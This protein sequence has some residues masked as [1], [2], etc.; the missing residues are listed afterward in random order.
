[1]KHTIGIRREDKNK[2][3]RRVPVVPADMADSIAVEKLQFVVQSSSL[4][5][6]TDDAFRKAGARVDDSLD[7]CGVVLAVKEIPSRLFRKG[8]TYVFFTHTVKGQRHNMG[9]LRRLMALKCNVID[10][11][12]IVNAAGQRLIFF[13]RHAGLAGMIDTLWG[14]GQ[15]LAFERVKPNPLAEVKLAHQYPNLAAA[16]DHLR[17]I[18]A[19]IARE[20]LPDGLAPFVVGFTGYGNVSAGAQEVLDTFP[21][22]TI[23]PEALAGLHARHACATDKIYKVVFREEHMA[24]PVDGGPFDLQTYYRHPERYRAAFD[25][26]L[27]H[28]TV[29]MNCI[30]W[31]RPYPR[32]ITKAALK[33]MFALSGG[34]RLKAIGDI[35]CDI[36]GAIE[37]TVKAT[38]P[39]NPVYVYE[40]EHDRAVDGVQ[41]NGPLIMAVDNLP[42]EFSQ[43]ASVYFSRALKPFLPALAAADYTVPFQQ[44]AL[45]P[46]IKGALIVHQGKFTP[47]YAFM[48][49][50]VHDP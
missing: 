15:R 3:E 24:Q 28:L 22:E 33:Q 35:S 16:M 38:E 46:E 34:A 32:L 30:Y 6:F 19:Q 21:V 47:P 12:R 9:M 29:L 23:A 18:G 40:P 8:V 14:V 26:Y 48:Q 42:C 37:A 7:S 17:R 50:F 2:W 20:G 39:D 44:L 25:T 10:Y 45:P 27:P 4:R 31:D 36:E 43:E 41:G 5:A 1:M 49:A 11:E 13:G